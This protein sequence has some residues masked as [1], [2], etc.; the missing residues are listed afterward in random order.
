MTAR[1]PEGLSAID[2][3]GKF[4]SGD[5]DFFL[6]G[7]KL[8]ERILLTGLAVAELGLV[9]TGCKTTEPEPPKPE[10]FAEQVVLSPTEEKT[11]EEIILEQEKAIAQIKQIIA[12]NKVEHIAEIFVYGQKKGK[13][14]FDILERNYGKV[15][16]RFF[17]VLDKIQDHQSMMIILPVESIGQQKDSYLCLFRKMTEEI[18]TQEDLTS[19]IVDYAGTLAEI[20]AEGLVMNNTPIGVQEIRTKI[21]PILYGAIVEMKARMKQIQ[22]S[23]KLSDHYKQT[24]LKQYST[25]ILVINEYKPA[26]NPFAKEALEWAEQEML[27]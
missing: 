12:E 17:T 13:D 27:K 18:K 15:D 19:L 6:W 4:E 23:E 7:E 11:A 9:L 24:V 20:N 2:W 1:F 10:L 22:N 8:L 5:G 26:E 21:G 14:L 3:P 25:A 16:P